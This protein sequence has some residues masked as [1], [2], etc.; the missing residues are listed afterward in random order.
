MIF[1]ITKIFGSYTYKSHLHPI[2]SPWLS[3]LFSHYYEL[4]NQVVPFAGSIPMLNFKKT[5]PIKPPFIPSMQIAFLLGNI[6]HVFLDT[7]R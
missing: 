4:L 3:P 6:R 7:L 1:P 5:A 2:V